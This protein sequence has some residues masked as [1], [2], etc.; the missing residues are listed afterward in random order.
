MCPDRARVLVY[1]HD[2][3]GLG[4]LRRSLLIAGRLAAAPEVGSVLIVTGSPKANAF[5]LPQGCDA[6]KLPSVTKTS[7]GRY[8]ARTL[9][10]PIDELTKVRASIAKSTFEAFDPDL[11]LV[12][13]APVGMMDELRPLLEAV[14][15]RPHRARIAL[16]LRDVIDDR[17]SV[18]DEWT[19]A[20]VWD[21]LAS[22]YDRVIVY[23]DPSVTTTAQELHLDKLLPRRVRHVGYLG[24]PMRKSRDRE[25]TI[26]VTAGGG[27]DGHEVLRAYAT[28]LESLT[29]TAP[30]RSVVVSGPLMSRRRTAE[31]SARFR[32]LPHP[33]EFCRFTDKMDDLLA[34]AWGVVSMAGYNTVVETLS[35]GV[36]ALLVP[37]ERPRLEQRIRAERIAARVAAI[38]WSSARDCTPQRIARFVGRAISNNS[39]A[40][41]AVDMNGLDGAIDVLLELLD[42]RQR[43][44]GTEHERVAASA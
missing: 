5:H 43:T 41:R 44:V 4:H 11:V 9:A 32:H 7:T 25:P 3:Y 8:T 33:I 12:D 18:H 17:A 40:T 37:R 6:V 26:L 2:T 35:A 19:R 14:G 29:H 16:G 31:L 23:G 10:L 28:Y 34:S 38:E 13:H 1:S 20:G 27:G 30:F 21:V 39:V 36:P 22:T 24:R 42:G 15:R